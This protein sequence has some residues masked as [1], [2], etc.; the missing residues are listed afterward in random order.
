MSILLGNFLI[1]SGVVIATGI[2]A[3]AVGYLMTR[4]G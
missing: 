2:V 3:G 4:I 1:A